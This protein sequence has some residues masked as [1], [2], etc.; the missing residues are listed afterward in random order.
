MSWR[1]ISA[2][3]AVA[4]ALA[5][6]DAEP[7][8]SL[9][10]AVAEAARE[11]APLHP[12]AEPELLVVDSSVAANVDAAALARALELPLGSFA[13]DCP[14]DD[15]RDCVADPAGAAYLRVDDYAPDRDPAEG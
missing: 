5:C 11:L 4:L 8:R 7:E 3:L 15:A 2:V 14:T 6:G 9:A 10:S 12:F 1:G 13:W